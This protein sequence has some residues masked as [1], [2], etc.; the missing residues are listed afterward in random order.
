MLKKELDKLLKKYSPKEILNMYCNWQIYIT[1]SQV[2]KLIKL[3]NEK[4]G[5][6]QW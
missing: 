4:E 2:D 6:K 5:K 1:S 3:K